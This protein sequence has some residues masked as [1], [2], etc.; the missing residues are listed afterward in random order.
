MKIIILHIQPQKVDNV[1]N[2]LFC[3]NINISIL[4]GLKYLS[5]DQNKSSK[6]IRNI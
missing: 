5:L 3:F 6:L 2:F 4:L 1:Y